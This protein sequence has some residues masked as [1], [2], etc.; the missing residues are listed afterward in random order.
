M[1]LSPGVLSVTW[2]VACGPAVQ[3]K[4]APKHQLAGQGSA[5]PE[6]KGT[7]RSQA[8]RGTAR[9]AV[10]PEIGNS[11]AVEESR[12]TPQG[13]ATAPTATAIMQPALRS[14]HAVAS[15]AKCMLNQA[16]LQLLVGHQS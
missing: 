9:M 15:V 3:A 8:K 13:K 11:M 4:L 12:H 6:V 2:A 14:W 1:V 5:V 10:R 16:M 7:S